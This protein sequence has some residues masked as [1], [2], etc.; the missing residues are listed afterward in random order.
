[1][2]IAF[3][4]AIGIL[5]GL[6]LV[7]CMVWQ[8]LQE[9][10]LLL[11]VQFVNVPGFLVCAALAHVGIGPHTGF[12]VDMFDWFLMGIMVQWTVIGI[13]CGVILQVR[14]RRRQGNKAEPSGPGDG[15]TRA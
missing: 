3:S 7:W 11:G 8:P 12:D 5:V 9:S 4:T 1:M 13:V 15:S 2:K 10:G 6:L 14:E